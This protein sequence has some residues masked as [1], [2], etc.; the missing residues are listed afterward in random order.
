MHHGYQWLD[1]RD[2]WI[3]GHVRSLFYGNPH[4]TFRVQ[5][6]KDGVW[7]VE[8][9]DVVGAELVGFRYDTLKPGDKVTVYGHASR[10]PKDK[11]M[12]GDKLQTAD[13]KTY[14]FF[15]RA[16]FGL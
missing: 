5:T 6:E 4:I 8:S 10:D 15:S 7:L 16:I 2:T 1:K 3:T 13:G 9:T 11:R 14:V 12:R